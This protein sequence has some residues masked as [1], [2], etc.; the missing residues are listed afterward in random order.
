MMH[1]IS[2]KN[3]RP[4][5]HDSVF[6]A[7]G[8]AIV[9]DVEIHQDASIWFNCVIRGDVAPIVIGQGTNIQDSTVIHTSRFD[10]G[11]TMI[12][13]NVTVGHMA[14]LHACTILDSAFVGMN[15]TVMDKAIIEEFGFLAAG[16]LLT[17]GKIVKSYQMFSGRPAKFVRD[18][19]EEEIAFMKD[20][21]S[22]YVRL[23][24]AYMES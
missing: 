22:H 23:A 11:R 7:Q 14:L 15:S 3:L 5:I 12:G 17:N 19:T 21:A 16:S 18:I 2:Y 6:V 13:K 8:A 10:D 24:K 1:N 4:K 20:N 9:G